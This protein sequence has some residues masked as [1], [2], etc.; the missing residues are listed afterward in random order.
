MHN[1]KLFLAADSGGSKT[2]WM[3]INEAGDLI[4][5][6]KTQG[7][8]AVPVTLPIKETVREAYESLLPHGSPRSIFLSLG[9]PNTDEVENALYEIFGE[10]IPISVQKEASGEAI[11]EA[12]KYMN[13]SAVVMCGTGSV[14][15]G[16]TKTGR[17]YSGGWGP[18]YG[19]GGSGGGM[20]SEALRMFLNSLDTHTDI[21]GISSLFST[22]TDGLDISSFQGRMELKRRA[23][24][25]SRREL[26]ALA[27]KIYALAEQGDKTA[28]SLYE[29]AAS[30]IVDLAI[31]VSEISSDFG[32]LLCGGFFTD[33][34]RLLALC[35]E[36]LLKRS[37]AR[38]VYE[39][40][41]SPIVASQLS[42]LRSSN[43]AITTELFEEL[44]N[45]R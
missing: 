31:G 30:K 41:F 11:L 13:C 23:I 42:V 20:G 34:P 7:L 6:V 4:K 26:A 12:A 44:L 36:Y 28:L 1:E 5:S 14:A 33:K 8:G 24:T 40:R 43:T 3:L 39:P 19:D 18:I 10:Q 27:P 35:R 38:L 9:G 25:M 45:N 21:G 17:K 16:D 2:V 22:L 15:V 29:K 37:N 32:I